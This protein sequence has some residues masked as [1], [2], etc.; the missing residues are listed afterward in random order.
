MKKIVISI[1]ILIIGL[2]GI[3]AQLSIEDGLRYSRN[4]YSGSARFT[5]MGGSFSALGGELSAI[6]INPAGVSIFRSSAISFTPT[7]S[8]TSTEASYLSNKES[9]FVYKIGID[10]FGIVLN[11]NP[12]KSSLIKHMNFGITYDKLNDFNQNLYIAS[13][14]MNTPYSLLDTY[15][16]DLNSAGSGINDLDPFYEGLAYDAFLI[17]Y[18]TVGGFYNIIGQN[19]LIEKRNSIERRGKQNEWNFSMGFNLNDMLYVGAAIGVQS[20]YFEQNSI[21]LEDFIDY[22]TILTNFRLTENT[23]V[24]GT[25]INLK[26]GFIAKPIQMLRI[27]GAIHTPTIIY[28]EEEFDSYIQSD[29]VTGTVYP[30]NADVRVDE[31]TIRTPFKLNAG[32]GVVLGKYGLLSVDY[33]FVDYSKINFGSDDKSYSSGLNSDVDGAFKNTSNIRTGAE[34]RLG[35]LALRGG[36]GFYQSPYTSK[37]INKD[38]DYYTIS[39]GFGYRDKNIFIDFGYVYHL[40]TENY[41]L[42]FDDYNQAGLLSEQQFNK[43]KIY[44]TIGFKF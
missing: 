29:L 39:G 32:L 11:Y 41:I 33:D 43:H 7:L 16:W 22:D 21:Y 38:A 26:L 25:G 23:L 3:Y 9:E 35:N 30:F 19:S 40:Y 15:V 5:S 31:Y 12:G 28:A 14:G 18:D 8:Q 42:N 1:F 17:D 36:F 27:S 34:M 37:T 2:S 6:P 4:I 13:G 20:I 44:V 10:N 24:T